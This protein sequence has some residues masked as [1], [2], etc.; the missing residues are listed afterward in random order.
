MFLGHKEKNWFPNDQ[1]MVACGLT[2]V[3]KVNDP[4]NVCHKE[5]TTQMKE[6]T[7]IIEDMMYLMTNHDYTRSLRR[8]WMNVTE[9]D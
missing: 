7:K 5:Y 3:T 2:L 1:R 8:K 6:P 4:F 9:S